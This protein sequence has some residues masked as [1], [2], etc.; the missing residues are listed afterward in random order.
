MGRV[1]EVRRRCMIL[2]AHLASESPAVCLSR[3]KSD[4]L[5]N[6]EE[7]KIWKGPRWK[8]QTNPYFLARVFI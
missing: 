8:A 4:R 7:R 3:A 2:L 5:L 6:K 1:T